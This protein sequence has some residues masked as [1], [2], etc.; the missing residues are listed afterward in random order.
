[1]KELRKALTLSILITD[2]GKL[3]F[4]QAE[5]GTELPTGAGKHNPSEHRLCGGTFAEGI[6]PG[7][8]THK[9]TI[10]LTVHGRHGISAKIY[11]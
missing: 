6:C 1:M 4:S 11:Y 5:D 10:N 3:T 2:K 8:F 7:L 9:T